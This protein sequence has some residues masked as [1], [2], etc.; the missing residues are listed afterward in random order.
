MLDWMVEPLR[1]HG[2]RASGYL[3]D[4]PRYGS[5]HEPRARARWR[6][7]APALSRRV[8][9]RRTAPG[10][11]SAPPA[12]RGH[13]RRLRPLRSSRRAS[14]SPCG[15]PHWPDA[16]IRSPARRGR[17]DALVDN[18]H[19]AA[20][21]PP[22]RLRAGLPPAR[23]HL[24]R[25]ADRRPAHGSHRRVARGPVP[26]HGALPLWRR[27]PA[28]AADYAALRH[29]HLKDCHT[30]SFVGSGARTAGGAP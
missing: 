14:T 27:R 15:W 24:H 28:R 10:C 9:S 29:V 1:R 18:L 17:W 16:T 25:D 26:G 30:A 23:G 22:S 20:E 19:A 12:E 8:G 6:V 3:G 7:P 2:A 5:D 11:R 13:S 4:G 21:M